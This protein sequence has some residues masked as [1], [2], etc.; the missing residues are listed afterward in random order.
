M[1]SA[2]RAPMLLSDA[3]DKACEDATSDVEAKLC[4]VGRL[5]MAFFGDVPVATLPYDRVVEFLQF[6]WPLPEGWGK[7]HGRDRF[8]QTGRDL[9]PREETRLA[10]ERDAALAA[11]ILA[12]DCISVPEKRQ[13][14]VEGSRR[15]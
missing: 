3:V 9:D 10:D 14:L 5:A 2:L 6:V 4:T 15:A 13:R 8:E 7:D 12:N 11:E 1:R